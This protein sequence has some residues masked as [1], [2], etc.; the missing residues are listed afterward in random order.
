MSKIKNQKSSNLQ[1]LKQWVNS[2]A[3]LP[4]L[5]RLLKFLKFSKR[6]INIWFVS[7]RNNEKI[8]LLNTNKISID[9][10]TEIY[11]NLVN[12]NDMCISSYQNEYTKILNN[13]NQLKGLNTTIQ[14]EFISLV[15][16][17]SNN[18][19]AS[20]IFSNKDYET[21][22]LC[23]LYK[24][25]EML[26]TT[27]R[28]L[29]FRLA[30][31]YYECEFLKQTQL[32]KK[33]LNTNIY[34]VLKSKLQQV[35]MVC[36]C[37][38]MTFFML[39]KKFLGY[40]YDEKVNEY[41]YNFIDLLI[42]DEAGQTSPE[43]AI[44]SF[45]LAKKAVVVGDDKQIPP[46]WGISHALDVT[47]AFENKVISSTSE[48][49]ILETNGLNT[50]QSSLMRVASLSC[51]YD[52]YGEPGLFLS[53][54]RRCYN[55]IIDY[56]NKLLYNNHLVPLRG[57]SKSRLPSMGYHNISVERAKKI[58]TSRANEHEAIEIAKWLNNN[59]ASISSDY[60]NIDKQKILAVITPFNAQTRKIEKAIKTYCTDIP[61]ADKIIHVGTVHKFQG[62]ERQIII[63]STV[64]GY[65]DE[66]N[67][68]NTNKNL[69]NVA[70]SRAKDA[71]GVFGS[72]ECLSKNTQDTASGLMYQYVSSH[73]IKEFI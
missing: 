3:E 28:Y 56:S 35:A 7:F 69:M 47:L 71:F 37:L 15:K 25:N 17:V 23:N 19:Y 65:N 72:I 10:I 21:L 12:E 58:G 55:E 27:L 49:K 22:K 52:K 48:F 13:Q 46:V 60:K 53:E 51:Q 24:T 73:E 14:N 16:M 43:I 33:Q 64:Y 67:F 5:V 70:V 54:H 6:K 1:R 45:A 40:K 11:L 68:I 57:L 2:Y 29:E 63:F 66:C 62:A 61:N 4:F 39:S 20:N 41:L 38:I 50:S 34:D 8:N 9:K 31:H 44:A 32:S 30:T 18:K 36:P 26:D 42:A 59:F